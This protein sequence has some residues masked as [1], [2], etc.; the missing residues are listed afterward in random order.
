MECFIILDTK[1]FFS[2]S[3]P[4]PLPSPRFL[5]PRHCSPRGTKINPASFYLLPQMRSGG[6]VEGREPLAVIA[7]VGSSS[8][9]CSDS[10][11]AGRRQK[12]KKKKEKKKSWARGAAR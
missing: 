11:D 4:P 12:K 2:P 1:H 9:M 8:G 3:L 7:A 5:P 6:G 10:D